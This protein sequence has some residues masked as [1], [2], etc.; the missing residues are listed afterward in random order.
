MDKTW[1]ITGVSSGLGQ[2]LAEKALARGDRVVGTSR[3]G[4]ALGALQGRHG[5]RLD[6]VALDLQD[7][8]AVRSAV[9][10]AFQRSGR[11]DMVVSNA[12]YGVFGAAEE[13]NDQQLHDILGVN[14]VGSIVLLRAALPHLRAQGGGRILQISSEGGQRAYPGFSLYHASKWGVEGFVESAAQEVAAFGIEMVLVEPGPARTAFGSHLVKTTPM[15]AYADTPVGPLRHAL[16]GGWTIRGD[17]DRMADAMLA[18]ADRP[19]PLPK[20]LVLGSDAYFG[21]RQAL[22]QRLSEL[23][24]QK[25][26]ALAADFT[27]QELAQLDAAPASDRAACKE[28]R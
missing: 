20:R 12:G 11:I 22:Q 28:L 6:I 10:R 17:P 14:L 1:L 4:N 27:A 16:D 19:G 8:R 15:A 9:D 2:R 24:D 13:T 23:E 26:A 21:V 18:L 7:L 25:D 3:D 5:D